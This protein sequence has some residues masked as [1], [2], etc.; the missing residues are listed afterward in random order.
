[1][2]DF[3]LI[4]IAGIQNKIVHQYSL[5]FAKISLGKTPKT[6]ATRKPIKPDSNL[7]SGE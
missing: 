2:S 3:L 4:N 7:S 6:A 1:M 5:K